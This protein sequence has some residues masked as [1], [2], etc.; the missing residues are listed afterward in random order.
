M[1]TLRDAPVQL[2]RDKEYEEDIGPSY[3]RYLGT[4][5]SAHGQVRADLFD[6]IT[7]VNAYISFPTGRNAG[8]VEDR[9]VEKLYAYATSQ[10]FGDRLRF[11]YT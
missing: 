1:E 10:G 4:F 11:L 7:V 5:F 3:G 9:Y 2:I 8:N 6:A